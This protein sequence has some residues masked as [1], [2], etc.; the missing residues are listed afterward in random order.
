LIEIDV[1]TR[2][3][4]EVPDPHRDANLNRPVRGGL[5]HLALVICGPFNEAKRN[6]RTHGL[7]L[8]GQ[9]EKHGVIYARAS[10]RQERAARRW[11]AD[12]VRAIEDARVRKGS[13]LDPGQ[14]PPGTLIGWASRYYSLG[15]FSLNLVVRILISATLTWAAGC[16]MG[17]YSMVGIDLLVLAL[18]VYWRRT[19]RQREGPTRDHWEPVLRDTVKL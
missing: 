16:L 19:D 5:G 13:P 7:R 14:L 3:A 17:I 8:Y 18:W 15:G 9:L 4:R 11:F 1:R 12:G 2:E 6:A 10:L